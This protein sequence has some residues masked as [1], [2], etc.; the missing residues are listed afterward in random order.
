MPTAGLMNSVTVLHKGSNKHELLILQALF[1]AS[2]SPTLSNQE[3]RRDR[4]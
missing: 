2:H 3:E 1:I 4:I